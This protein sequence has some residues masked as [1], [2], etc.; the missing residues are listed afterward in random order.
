MQWLRPHEF[1]DTD[2][3][4]FSAIPLRTGQV[5]VGLLGYSAL[6]SALNLLTHQHPTIP[7]LFVKTGQEMKGRYCIRI[8]NFGKAHPIYIDDRIPCDVVFHRPV[9][10]KS[11]ARNEFWVMLLEKALAKFYGNAAIVV[12]L[13]GDKYGDNY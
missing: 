3:V 10:C 6:A 2:P 1:C 4:L 8:Y 12:L 7:S 13:S 11:V 5:T 9:F